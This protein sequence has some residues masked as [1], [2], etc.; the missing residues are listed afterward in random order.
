MLSDSTLPCKVHRQV[1][2]TKLFI[3]IVFHTNHH[4]CSSCFNHNQSA[5]SRRLV[6]FGC[7]HSIIN[8][9]KLIAIIGLNIDWNWTASLVMSR[10]FCLLCWWTDDD[11]V[12]E[13]SPQATVWYVVDF[14]SLLWNCWA[15]ND[16]I[17][18]ITAFVCPHFLG[19]PLVGCLLQSCLNN[20]HCNDVEFCFSFLFYQLSTV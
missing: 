15:H 20:N 16:I 18:T 6:D 3:A 5:R 12:Q 4:C 14:A 17:C 19:I 7:M 9:L 10:S 2:N 11:A 1:A 13:R 8:W